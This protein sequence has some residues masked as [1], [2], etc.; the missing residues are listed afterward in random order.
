MPLAGS[1]LC[2]SPRLQNYGLRLV[3][4]KDLHLLHTE[5]LG[6][7]MTLGLNIQ[8]LFHLARRGSSGKY[9]MRPGKK[10]KGRQGVLAIRGTGTASE[11]GQEECVQ[12]R[13]F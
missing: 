11:H 9:S 3:S 12:R 7:D 13:N 4:Y 2:A 6:V 1:T 10:R 8:A 5:R